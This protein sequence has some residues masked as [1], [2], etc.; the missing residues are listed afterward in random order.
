MLDFNKELVKQL[1]IN[2]MDMNFDGMPNRHPLSSLRDYK[3]SRGSPFV[4]QTEENVNFGQPKEQND[5]ISQSLLFGD[6]IFDDN[7]LFPF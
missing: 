5:D 2:R 3:Q 4:N 6:S 7:P 1:S